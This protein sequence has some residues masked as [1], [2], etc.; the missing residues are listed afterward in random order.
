MRPTEGING[1]CNQSSSCETT[2]NS[3]QEVRSLQ[4]V[5]REDCVIEHFVSHLHRLQSDGVLVLQLVVVAKRR[6]GEINSSS[7]VAEKPH[8]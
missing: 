4:I 6:I 2:Y 8:R 7:P 5:D 3:I 1:Q